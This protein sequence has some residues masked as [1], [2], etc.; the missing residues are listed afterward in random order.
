MQQVSDRWALQE[1][2]SANDVG[3][4]AVLFQLGYTPVTMVMSLLM[5][6]LGPILYQRSGD[7]TDPGRNTNVHVIGWRI[8]YVAL[9]VTLFCFAATSALHEWI[10]SILVAQ[11]Y[12]GSSQ[13]LP[14]VVLAGG[15]FS[16]GQMLALKLMSEMKSSAMTTVKI[17]TALIGALLN[18]IGS[19][20]AGVRG[21]VAALV[22]FS[23]IYFFCMAVLG[24]NS[25]QGSSGV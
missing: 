20:V 16:A 12:R 4:Y 10:F 2:G 1:Y 13:L 17:V 8:T 3:Q 24:K 18:L 9:I 23:I 6:F 19:S 21:V 15:I 14:W 22:A 7:A 5:G 11:E 25:K